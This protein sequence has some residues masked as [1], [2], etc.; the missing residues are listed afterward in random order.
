MAD[1]GS[2]GWNKHINGDCIFLL[3]SHISFELRLREIYDLDSVENAI[4]FCFPL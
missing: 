4:H 1:K 2:V 3:M